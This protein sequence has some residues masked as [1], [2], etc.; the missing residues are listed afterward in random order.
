MEKVTLSPINQIELQRW[1]QILDA[2]NILYDISNNRGKTV[3]ILAKKDAMVWLGYQP[4][5]K[6]KNRY[7][8]ALILLAI[9]A[10]V[11]VIVLSLPTDAEQKAQKEQAAYQAMTPEQRAIQD[12]IK[13]VQTRTELINS[14]FSGWDGAH[15]KL[16]DVVKK[17]LHNPKSFK[18]VQSGVVE[19]HGDWLLVI[20]EYRAE[21]ALG[22]MRK[23]WIKAKVAEDGTILKVIDQGTY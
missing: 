21:N 18:H 13:A 1:V 12:S 19:D 23:A 5:V 2:N 17:S 7:R 4:Q 15:T 8:P 22:A 14:Q 9:A 6:N 3:L 20:M 10:V 16:K 11:W